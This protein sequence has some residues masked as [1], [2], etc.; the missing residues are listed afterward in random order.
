MLLTEVFDG[1]RDDVELLFLAHIDADLGRRHVLR[2][3]GG[4]L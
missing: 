2:E 3:L 4:A 1:A